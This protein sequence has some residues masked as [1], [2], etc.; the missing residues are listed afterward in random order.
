[1][2][3]AVVIR[4]GRPDEVEIAAVLI[5]LATLREPAPTPAPARRTGTRP[6]RYTAPTSWRGAAGRTRW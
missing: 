3:G 4:G 2:T 1:M 6:A 5:A